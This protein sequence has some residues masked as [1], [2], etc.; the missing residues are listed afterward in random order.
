MSKAFTTSD[1]SINETLQLVSRS[2]HFEN[3]TQK[4]IPKLKIAPK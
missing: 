3:Q 2:K 1:E 4:L